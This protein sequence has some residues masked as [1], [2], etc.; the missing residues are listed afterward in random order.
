MRAHIIILSSL[1]ILS[2]FSF[3]LQAQ[4]AEV[5]ADGIIFPTMTTFPTSPAEGQVIYYTGGSTDRYMYYDG[6]TWKALDTTGGGGSSVTDMIVDS[7][8]GN[9]RVKV[10][11]GTY[12]SIIFDLN[13]EQKMNLFNNVGNQAKL[14]L[15]GDLQLI[16][17]TGRI[18]FWDAGKV[19][20]EL[21]FDGS[22]LSLKNSDS[23]DLNLEALGDDILLNSGDDIFFRSGGITRAVMN[24]TGDLVL[25]GTNPAARLDIRHDGTVNDPAIKISETGA[26][27]YARIRMTSNSNNE[28]WLHQARSLGTDPEYLF[29]YS[30]NGVTKNILTIDGDDSRTG[31][32]DASPE[33]ALEVRSVGTDDPLRVRQG[34]ATKLMVHDNG[35]VSIGSPTRPD[36]DDL[37]EIH[38]AVRIVPESSETCSNSDDVGKLYFD[39]Q[40]DKLKVC[41]KDDNGILPGGGFGWVNLH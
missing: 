14:L 8:D 4:E 18:E 35:A 29:T 21:D 28:Y 39:V 9:G 19:N 37:L 16:D 30:D 40:D 11:D 24:E 31:I 25:G 7:G 20:S 26:L 12:D 1:F 23:G 6:S 17:G 32:N 36:E 13:K 2:T 27:D 15:D 33:A 38:D 41:V 3:Q 5:R 10:N 22:T 34:T